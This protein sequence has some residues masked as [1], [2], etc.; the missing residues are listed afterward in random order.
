MLRI[1]KK[2]W[3]FSVLS[4]SS[5]RGFHGGRE[6]R[7]RA[8]SSAYTPG[9]TPGYHRIRSVEERNKVMNAMSFIRSEWAGGSCHCSRVFARLSCSSSLCRDEIYCQICKQLMENRKQRSLT[10]GWILL[11]VC[12]GI[13][14]PTELFMKVS[15]Q[16]FE[17]KIVFNWMNSGL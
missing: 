1:N 4:S 12:L 7:R 15:L 9:K 13:F 17:M 5:A 2:D 3:L 14:P 16:Q 11:S 6:G 8:G 10:Q